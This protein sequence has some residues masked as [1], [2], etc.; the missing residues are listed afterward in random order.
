MRVHY[1]A[2]IAFIAWQTSPVSS[3]VA[4]DKFIDLLSRA[5][6]KLNL[7]L[8]ESPALVV[9]VVGATDEADRLA[10]WGAMDT[11]KVMHIVLI[12]PGIMD[13][14]PTTAGKI[15]VSYL[16]GLYTEKSIA[17]LPVAESRVPDLVI[18]FNA[19]AF[20]CTW[21]RALSYAITT[22]N[23]VPVVLVLK[24]DYESRTVDV[25]INGHR[26]GNAPDTMSNR[27]SS[28]FAKEELHDCDEAVRNL[29]WRVEFPEAFP[30]PEL[31]AL[32]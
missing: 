7:N 30:V 3:G 8:L 6:V 21:R 23:P 12:G 2:L 29:G 18:A 17:R 16:N 19:D 32:D 20:K 24:N 14:Q 26:R 25:G 31:E 13:G 10:P 4:S 11:G 1:L 15:T 5:I 27:G 22:L 28:W 9:H